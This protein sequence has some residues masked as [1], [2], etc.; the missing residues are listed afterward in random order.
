[1]KK[2]VLAGILFILSA[3][4]LLNA[5]NNQPDIPASLEKLFGRLKINFNSSERLAINDSIRVIIEGYASSD[6]V[7]N[8]RFQNLRYLG[9]I[10][11]PDS[12]LKIITWNLILEDGN[13]RYFCDLIRR[14]QKTSPVKVYYL[15]GSYREEPVRSDTIYSSSDWYGALYY[16]IR[17]FRLNDQTNYVI[18]GIDYGNSFITRKII[19]VLWFNSKGEIV[20]GMK[21]FNDGKKTKFRSVFEFASTAVMSLRF[22]TDSSIVFDHLAPFS[23]EYKDNKQFY[24]PDFSFDSYDLENGIWR[25]KTNVDVRKKE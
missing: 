25:F 1:M 19:D 7:F 10:T 6:T 5:Q 18:L 8:H 9:Q 14:S 12:L 20:F 22:N 23:P 15:S 21:C 16:D 11:S 17:P 4:S 3:F 13:N 24:G 2:K